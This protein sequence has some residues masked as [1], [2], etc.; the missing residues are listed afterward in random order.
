M[1]WSGTESNFV[2]SDASQLHCK[3]TIN[4]GRFA[5]KKPKKER[6]MERSHFCVSIR[7][8]MRLQLTVDSFL[9]STKNLR[10]K[11]FIIY[12]YIYIIS[13]FL[14]FLFFIPYTYSHENCQLSTEE[15]FMSF[16]VWLTTSSEYVDFPYVKG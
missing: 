13:Y 12:I 11:N 4:K 14:T 10:T 1:S 15:I 8:S 9:M 3:D 5:N 7:K 2:Q 6:K 16:P